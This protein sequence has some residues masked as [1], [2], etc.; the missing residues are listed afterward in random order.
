MARK[1][2][3]CEMETNRLVKLRGFIVFAGREPARA[4]SFLG[5]VLLTACATVALP[6]SGPT[7]M[8][9]GSTTM[10]SGTA[11]Y[12]ASNTITTNGTF[13]VGGS[14][15]VL[16]QAGIQIT[17]TPGFNA[18]AGSAATT[19]HA[20]IGPLASG[21]AQV[22][23]TQQVNSAATDPFTFTD[24][25][26]AQLIAGG[27]ITFVLTNGS[28][29]VTNQCPVEFVVN[30]GNPVTISLSLLD[31][32]PGVYTDSTCTINPSASYVTVGSETVT[33]SLNV[34]FSVTGTYYVNSDAIDTS[35]TLLPW[36]TLGTWNV[37]VPPP[38]TLTQPGNV[39]LTVG[40][41]DQPV[42]V[43]EN[44]SA[45]NYS[46]SLS[47]VQYASYYID[48]RGYY[49]YPATNVLLSLPSFTVNSGVGVMS[50]QGQAMMN[51]ETVGHYEFDYY[52]ANPN[53]TGNLYF[54]V[55]MTVNSAL[56]LITG[57]SPNSGSP[58][59]TVTIYGASFGSS[60]SA[61]VVNISGKAATVTSVGSSG[62]VITA[63]VPNTNSGQ[64]QVYVAGVAALVSQGLNTTFY[65]V[66]AQYQ[67]TTFVNPPSAGTITLSPPGPTYASGQVVTVQASPTSGYLF[68]SFS[69][70]LNGATNPQ[71]LT[72]TGPMTVTAN[73]IPQTFNI[74]DTTILPGTQGAAQGT[75]GLPAT[76]SVT[77][78]AGLPS[79]A[80][81]SVSPSNSIPT[82][83]AFDLNVQVPA[84]TAISD[85][86]AQAN[87]SNGSW[88]NQFIVHVRPFQVFGYPTSPQPVTQWG[89]AVQCP[90]QVTTNT[91]GTI[92]IGV[93]GTG[94]P[95]IAAFAD[96][97]LS[98]GTFNV[99]IVASDLVPPGNYSLPLTVQQNLYTQN[100]SIPLSI[101]AG[102]SSD[103]FTLHTNLGQLSIGD[104]WTTFNDAGYWIPGCDEALTL[105][106]CLQQVVST[107]TN[108]Y[109]AQGV[110]GVRLNV[111]AQSFVAGSRNHPWDTTHALDNPPICGSA[112]AT[113]GC[114]QVTD[115]G[116]PVDTFWSNFNTLLQD[117]RS[118]GIRYVVPELGVDG[119]QVPAPIP[120]AGL[121]SICS[122]DTVYFYPWEPYGYLYNGGYAPDCQFDSR[123][124][125]FGVHTPS[126]MFWGWGNAPGPTPDKYYGILDKMFQA[127]H[128]R[129]TTVDRV[130]YLR[131]N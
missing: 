97:L 23:G 121:T 87:L 67:L 93:T 82:N 76:V 26:G 6:Q 58:G 65:V 27:D 50:G 66:G 126:N 13:T 71:N 20:A 77:T 34:A 10:N 84:S 70:N 89:P 129:P 11:A 112:P 106:Q 91:R 61:I 130:R 109:V 4:R 102:P 37:T 60:V 1:K 44:I 2:G 88:S 36:Q 39:S 108:S 69:G 79:G 127:I 113:Q 119:Y 43:S 68:N 16:L 38:P 100:I 95:G 22:A 64:L 53:G 14:A 78:V 85:Y 9:L 74:S 56:P 41:N 114:G 28:G 18:T 125:V 123:G 92:S 117:L 48:S 5:L 90:V 46:G 3:Q 73:F 19:F 128:R 103:H 31:A 42:S 63:I 86:P 35:G 12:Q 7:N 21:I 57:F 52:I 55:T 111:T 107:G 49:Y 122:S 32:A 15:S 120:L 45:P 94:I 30:S 62:T 116:G 25:L 101:T 110:T 51:A 131:R 105:R 115:N 29:I 96:P 99:R 54:T 75:N 59:S 81:W 80:S 124:Y 83:S 118:Y 17:L 98:S 104:Y 47:P 8:T 33:I 40:T 24:P 72:M